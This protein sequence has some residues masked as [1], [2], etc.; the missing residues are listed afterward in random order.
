[1]T[2]FKSICEKPSQDLT[3]GECAYGVLCVVLG[4]AWAAVKFVFRVLWGGVKIGL[5]ALLVV[6][7]LFLRFAYH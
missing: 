4:S 1:M 7:G 3:W 6:F 2:S 5:K